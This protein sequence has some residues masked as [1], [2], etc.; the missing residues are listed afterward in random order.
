MPREYLK[1]LREQ[2]G[3]SMMDMADRIGISRQYYQ[4]IEAGKKQKKMDITLVISLSHI[5]G[6]SPEKIIAQEISQSLNRRKSK[7]T[8]S[9]LQTSTA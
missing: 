5:F 3:M 1:E 6:I 8:N 7:W 9:R 4:Q 2:R